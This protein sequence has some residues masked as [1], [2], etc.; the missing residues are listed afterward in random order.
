MTPA[1]AWCERAG[2]N[3][4]PRSE[5]RQRSRFATPPEVQE[6]RGYT[7]AVRTVIPRRVRW[8]VDRARV[9]PPGE[10]IHRAR[11][12]GLIAAERA[13]PGEPRIVAGPAV[14]GW[15]RPA[16]APELVTDAQADA[17]RAL[18]GAVEDARRRADAVAEGRLRYFGYPEAVVG[19]DPDWNRD[20]VAGRDWPMVHW[21]QVNH[22]E[23]GLDP[24]WVW[25]M[26]RHQGV[27]QL[28]R[29]WRLSGDDRYAGAAVRW[30]DGFIAQCPPG[31]GIH[32]RSGLELGIRLVSWAWIVELLRGSPAL[33]P[34]FSGRLLS[35]VAAHLDHLGRYPSRY[36]SA[37]NHQVGEEAG[38]AVGGMCFPEVP[39]ADGHAREGLAALGEALSAQVL[40]DGVNAEQAVGYHGFV[41]EL[42]LPVAACLRALGR[43]VPPAVAEP[44]AGIAGFMG[45]LASDA[46]TLPRIG[47]ED[48][49]L[50]VD[51]GPAMG[52]EDRLRFRLRAAVALLDAELP[53][54]EPGL[55]EPTLWLCGADRARRAAAAEARV[56]GSAAFPHGGYA[57]LRSRAGGREVR[58]VLDA[59]PMGLAPMSAHG[60][61]DLLSVCVAVDGRE[62]LIDPGTFTYFGE[63][64]WRDYGRSTTAHSTVT[65]DGREQAEPA[66]RFMWRSQPAASLD[67][68]TGEDG[69]VRARGRHD[70]YAPVR[71]ERAVTLEG[72]VLTVIDELTGPE[73][74]HDVELRWHL[75][76]GTAEG[77][78]RDGWTW[79]DG[80]GPVRLAV[81][82]LD[83]Q[84]VVSGCESAPLGFA[85]EG[86]ERRTPSPTLVARGRVR[87]P[88]RLTSRLEAPA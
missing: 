4:H 13:R 52:E 79:D 40:P 61:A 55:D 8:Y 81:E 7:A 75:A 19:P 51:L 47:D 10:W 12:M 5:Y 25:E 2:A 85:S 83:D 9:M 59:G 22:R 34:E 14:A 74:E 84:R 69:V 68:F 3:G 50:G 30:I 48:E 86:L 73:G 6:G 53:R 11:Q 87:L 38:R 26:G 32:W 36:S 31:R 65:V 27:V 44:L 45:T 60:H 58:A 15:P 77:S 80:A 24:K 66:G 42:G 64:R 28:A 43:P 39:G 33:T 76:P 67:E 71:H 16:G 88:A 62:V 41:L 20:P 23:L 17:V 82:G 49:G 1:V 56:P 63:E 70:A 78:A 21:S 18:P 46:L 57:V 37:N 29:A 72:R 35:S 54:Q